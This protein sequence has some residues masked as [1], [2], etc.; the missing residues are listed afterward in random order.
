MVSSVSSRAQSV[1]RHDQSC[2]RERSVAICVWTGLN[3]DLRSDTVL[4]QETGTINLVIASFFCVA[5]CIWVG[6][7]GDLRSDTV[8][9]QETGTINLVIA[10]EAWRSAFGLD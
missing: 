9:G 6:L 5:I 7:N 3:G 10:S 1:D 4:G 2:H 8:L